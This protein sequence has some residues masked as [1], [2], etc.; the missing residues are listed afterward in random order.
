[1]Y[2]LIKHL[3]KY[4]SKSAVMAAILLP[5]EKEL[6]RI[7]GFV[8]DAEKQMFISEATTALLRVFTERTSDLLTA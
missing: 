1:M 5:Q 3:P 2:D 8:E 6:E 4:Y 7:I